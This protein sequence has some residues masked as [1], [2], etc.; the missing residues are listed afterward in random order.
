MAEIR[1]LTT[2]DN[3]KMIAVL[4]DNVADNYLRAAIMEAQEVGL[5]GVL[6]TPLLEALKDKAS[7]GELTG[8]Y[9]ELVNSY[10][11]YYLAYATKAE[12]LHKLAYKARNAGVV[13]ADA[14]G[15][16]AAS[17]T[18]IDTEVA[19]AQAKA[20]FHCF[21]MQGWLYENRAQLPELSQVAADRIAATL[22]SA[23]NTC[24]IWLGGARGNWYSERNR[25][26]WEDR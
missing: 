26:L 18:E 9:A 2:A 12:L 14:E 16:E 11:V 24:P 6:G 20:D 8:A 1:L 13:K 5:R 25:D 10:A 15:Y 3:V 22:R 7:R 21:R 23:E 17:A 4:D 19:R